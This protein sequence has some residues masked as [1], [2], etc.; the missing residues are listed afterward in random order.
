MRTICKLFL[1]S[2]SVSSNWRPTVKFGLLLGGWTKMV[3]APEGP[4]PVVRQI[5]TTFGH[6]A[7][8]LCS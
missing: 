4:V 8:S 3:S 7:M 2:I 1:L 5:G 6:A